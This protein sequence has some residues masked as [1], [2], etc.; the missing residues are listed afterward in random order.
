MK[1]EQVKKIGIAAALS[2]SMLTTTAPAVVFA[3]GV[4]NAGTTAGVPSGVATVNANHVK[5]E[6]KV[7]AK[8]NLNK[9]EREMKAAKEA[10]DNAKA[11][12]SENSAEHEAA[13]KAY[14]KSVLAYNEAKETADNLFANVVA[15]KTKAVKEAAQTEVNAK[16]K[17]EAAKT[18][19]KEK[20]EAYNKAVSDKTAAED[21][22]NEAK[23]KHP[24]AE[25]TLAQDKT[26]VESAKTEQ[27]KANEKLAEATKNLET[28]K[29]NLTEATSKKEGTAKTLAD[30][31]AE[32]QAA[33]ANVASKQSELNDAKAKLAALTAGSPEWQAASQK[34]SDAQDAL[35]NANTALENA[36]NNEAAKKVTYEAANKKYTEALASVA[37][38]QALKTELEKKKEAKDAAST[39]KDTKTQA[40]SD[41]ESAVNTANGELNTLQDKVNDATQ[42]ASE[43]ENDLNNANQALETAKTNYEKAK[44]DAKSELEAAKLALNNAGIEFL[45]SKSTYK[46]LEQ[47]NQALRNTT[48]AKIRNFFELLGNKPYTDENDNT[49]KNSDGSTKTIWQ[50]RIESLSSPEALLNAM[51]MVDQV[52]E[53]IARNDQP[54]GAKTPAKVNVDMMLYSMISNALCMNMD[55]HSLVKSKDDNLDGPDA[56]SE[57]QAFGF[58]TIESAVKAWYEEEKAKYDAGNRNFQ[59]VGHYLIIR[60]AGGSD[61]VIGC[62]TSELGGHTINFSRNDNLYR[63]GMTTDEFRAA[64]RAQIAT[65]KKAIDDAAAKLEKLIKDEMPEYKAAKAAVVEKQAAKAAADKKVAEAKQ[66]VETKKADIVNL[67]KTLTNASNELDKATEKYNNANDAYTNAQNVVS[68][69]EV[70]HPDVATKVADAEQARD[71]AKAA[72]D[73]AKV[74]LEQAQE[75]KANREGELAAAKE[76]FRQLNEDAS[77]AQDRVTEAQAELDKAN[78]RATKAAQAEVN[79][80][81]ADNDAQADVATNALEKNNKETAANQA[82]TDKNNADAAVTAATNKLT[83][84]EAAYKEVTDAKA[85]VEEKAA[86]L[87][88][89]QTLLN[90]ANNAVTEATSAHDDAVANKAAAEVLLTKAQAIVRTNPATY[91]DFPELV[92]AEN[93]YKAAENVVTAKQTVLATAQATANASETVL[94]N[95]KRDYENALVSYNMAKTDLEEFVYTLSRGADQVWTL[96]SNG[97]ATYR[98][99]CRNAVENE[100]IFDNFT[101]VT[102]DGVEVDASSYSSAKGSLILNLNSGFLN[103]LS[104]GNHNVAISFADG[105]VV[106]TSL[107][108]VHP[109]QVAGNIRTGRVN[110]RINRNHPKT[111]DENNLMAEGLIFMLS[112]LALVKLLRRKRSTR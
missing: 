107:K 66:A 29:A 111:G 42:K 30:A 20:Q 8:E 71:N 28:A 7:Q 67:N 55:A 93:A 72:Y 88:A 89:A 21:A 22:L 82:A 65:K 83:A 96:G 50:Q 39:E 70:A 102:V 12:H 109:S 57:C 11:I 61:S 10:M 79:A 4:P 51:D 9:A 69:Y 53:R 94:E 43:A 16:T 58:P 56:L 40:K 75:A 84:D 3:D 46:T 52:N 33:N 48:D 91:A 54:K 105:E 103:K 49:Q 24:N 81:Q 19:Q 86:S 37:E 95:A 98:V 100:K 74:S 15:D 77:K 78:D 59:E 25:E 110:S 85:V 92:S 2:T 17:L 35:N 38:Y 32:V 6:N 34:V 36:K 13:K 64:L 47:W 27:K 18:I 73:A 26:D 104:A 90:A 68:A 108:V 5:P 23:A 106:T 60:S 31:K 97:Q 45:N 99:T 80:T 63:N 41:A 1:K 76:E 62:S 44:A 112:N 87:N 14:D 101:K